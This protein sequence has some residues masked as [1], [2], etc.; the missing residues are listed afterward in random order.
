MEEKDSLSSVVM[1][2]TRGCLV[3]PIQTELYDDVMLRIQEDVLERIKQTGVKGVIIDVSGVDTID[4]FLGQAISDTVRMTSMLGAAT[5]LTGLK[6]E[7]VASL[8]DL[9]VDF[10]GIRTAIN[11][12]EGFKRLEPIVLHEE[13]DVE[14]TEEETFEDPEVTLDEDEDIG[15]NDDERE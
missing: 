10:E 14:E 4:S 13:E 5:I 3:V 12:E 11:I 9:E 7:V 15:K 1:H 2:I 6:P 8:V